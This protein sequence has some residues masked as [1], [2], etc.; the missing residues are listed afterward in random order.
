[1]AAGG[2]LWRTLG[3]R[4]FVSRRGKIS[5]LLLGS[6]VG[7]G[8]S[9]IPLVVV[10]EVA[11]GMIEGIT[12]RYLEVGTYHFQVT[13]AGNATLDS[14][15]SLAERLRSSKG[16]TR[17]IPERQGMGLLYTESERGGGDRTGRAPLPVPGG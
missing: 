1:V 16:I 4:T 6:I 7:I 13:L 11:D 5:N 17:V 14:Y 10:L 9:L 15:E 8:L 12:R 2:R 3:L